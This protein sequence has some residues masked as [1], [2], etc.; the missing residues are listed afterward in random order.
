MSEETFYVLREYSIVAQSC[1]YTLDKVRILY[2]S[3]K[4]KTMKFWK[5]EG[6]GNNVFKFDNSI[7]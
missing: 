5:N 1:T 4:G 2:K 7:L 3:V 6:C